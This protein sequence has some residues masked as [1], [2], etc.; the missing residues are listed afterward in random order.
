MNSDNS[1]S[2]GNSSAYSSQSLFAQ[3]YGGFNLCMCGFF[4]SRPKWTPMRVSRSIS[5]YSSFYSV[6]QILAPLASLN[7][8]FFPLNSVR[9]PFSSWN[10]VLCTGIQK[11]PL[12]RKPVL[13]SGK[14]LWVES[15]GKLSYLIIFRLRGH[16]HC[17]WP[18]V[19]NSDPSVYFKYI[20]PVFSL[21]TAGVLSLVPIVPLWLQVEVLV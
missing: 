4:L 18:N 8:D 17:L 13:I 2:F 11:L 6:L 14:C 16:Y 1:V 19:P 15:W 5:S 7:S 20:F 3:L 12:G 9:S 21:F 10:H